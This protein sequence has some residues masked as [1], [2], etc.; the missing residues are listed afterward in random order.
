MMDALLLAL[1]FRERGQEDPAARRV[2]PL[3]LAIFVAIQA[4]QFFVPGTVW[5]ADLARAYGALPLP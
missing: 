5:F 1:I 3:M 4:P 2:F